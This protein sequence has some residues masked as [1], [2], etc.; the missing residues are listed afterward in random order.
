ML[1]ESSIKGIAAKRLTAVEIDPD[2]S[3]QHEFNSMAQFKSIL[4][5]EKRQLQ[6]AFVWL[7]ADGEAVLEARDQLTWYDARQNNPER[8]EFHLYYRGNPVLERAQVNDLLIFIV[9]SD[10]RVTVLLCPAGSPIEDQLIWLFD[11]QDNG[12][13]LM[14][15]ALDETRILLS[16]F[17]SNEILTRIGLSVAMRDKAFQNQ[18][19]SDFDMQMP[20]TG[21]LA[22]YIQDRFGR[23]YDPVRQ[24]DDLL[25]HLR[26]KE[27]QAFLALEAYELDLRLQRGFANSNDF[28][29][30]SLSIQN[31]RKSRSGYSFEHHIAFL[32]K[33]N[34]LPF[35]QGQIT[36]NRNRPDFILPGIDAY[37]D[38]G[39][40]PAK[41]FALGAKTTAK[42]RWR[43][44][45]SESDRVAHKHL[46]TLEPAISAHQLAEMQARQV[47]PV[48]PAALL[49]SYPPEYAGM[50]LT[51]RDFFEQLQ[52]KL[53]IKRPLQTG[54]I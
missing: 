3:H 50:L 16:T 26:Q 39:Y 11:I 15:R 40:D 8:S 48:V 6:A 49:N 29:A 5:A 25:L 37:R 43:Q 30:C 38:P 28:I 23:D 9:L 22:V 41:L 13:R 46:A 47:T 33:A 21:R 35:S 51:F 54:G 52:S 34:D 24:P 12:P 44:I 31:R 53:G 10:N 36:E 2:R 32:L 4:G 19:L 7:A 42:D 45:L 18:V 14:V 20:E 1:F 17:I 27:E